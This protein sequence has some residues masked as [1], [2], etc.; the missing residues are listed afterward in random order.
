MRKLA[1]NAEEMKECKNR[2]DISVGNN[3]EEK[4][5][6]EKMEKYS[7]YHIRKENFEHV[8]VGMFHMIQTVQIG[9]KCRIIL[10]YDPA[11][12]KVSIQTFMNKSDMEQ[13]QEKGSQWSLYTPNAQ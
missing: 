2:T 8:L 1:E 13:V 4:I 7:I 10:D 5:D 6:A 11:L 3:C 9:K 12:S